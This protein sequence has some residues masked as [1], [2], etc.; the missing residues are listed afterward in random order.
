[1]SDEHIRIEHPGKVVEILEDY[2][3]VEISD[4]SACASCHAKGVCSASDE[5]IK[6]IDVPL[7]I[8]TL[9][10]HYEVGEEVI[11]VMSSSLGLKAAVLAYAVP[12]FVLLSA[13]FIASRFGVGELYV[14]LSGIAGV[15]LYYLVLLFF[16]RK[17][18]RVFTFSIEKLH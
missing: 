6:F 14:G 7:T 16:R 2:I 10:R 1:M 5:A 4:K 3:R 15:I 9:S 17:L 8:G 12:L 18:A 11:V 13:M